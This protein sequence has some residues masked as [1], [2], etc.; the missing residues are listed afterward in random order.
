MSH[1]QGQ[2]KDLERYI[3][4]LQTKQVSSPDS[5][6]RH[7]LSHD[8]TSH[9]PT[10]H[11]LTSPHV[12]TSPVLVSPH[13]THRPHGISLDRQHST[14]KHVTFAKEKWESPYDNPPVPQ[15]RLSMT[16]LDEG[17]ACAVDAKRCEWEK[18]DSLG[19]SLHPSSQVTP[20]LRLALPPLPSPT[21]SPNPTPSPAP[22]S[23][24][25]HAT[26]SR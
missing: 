26:G 8:H 1:L 16:Q 3:T 2:I 5:E 12:L 10:S 9:D 21:P 24:I 13:L 4:F 7:S 11:D 6:H 23:H 15:Y 25:L 14:S 22:C 17:V 18:M 20:P 19:N